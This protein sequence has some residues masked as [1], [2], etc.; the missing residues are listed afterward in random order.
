MIAAGWVSEV[1]ALLDRGYGVELPS[2]SSLGYREI[3]GHLTEGSPLP[4]AVLRIKS[5]THRLIRQQYGWFRLNDGAVRWFEGSA[6]GLDQAA[7]WCCER[8]V[9]G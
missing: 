3:A 7:S 8:L 9:E 6:R 4:D 1:A 2:M 5:R